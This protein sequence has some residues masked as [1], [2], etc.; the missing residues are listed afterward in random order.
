[1]C[2]AISN[3]KLLVAMHLLL[4][5]IHLLLVAFLLC[6]AAI[7]TSL[8]VDLCI[9]LALFHSHACL[10][11]LVLVCRQARSDSVSIAVYQHGPILLETSAVLSTTVEP[12]EPTVDCP[13]LG[14]GP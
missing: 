13:P 3:K 2:I 5:A 6:Q 11:Y 10:R 9:P 12:H 1:M 7:L 4:V 14:G 8:Q